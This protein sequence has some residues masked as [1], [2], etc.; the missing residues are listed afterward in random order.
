[1]ATK[2][3]AICDGKIEEE[4]GKVLGTM[5]K[6]KNEGNKNELIYVCS[7]CQKQENWIEKAKVKSA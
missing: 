2:K 3:C 6:V 4:Y 1:M 5:V 7:A